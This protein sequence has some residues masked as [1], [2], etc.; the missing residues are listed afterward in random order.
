MNSRQKIQYQRVIENVKLH[1][2]E[3]LSDRYVNN[4]DKLI[5]KCK[6]DHIFYM[7]WKHLHE[8][9]WCPI[10]SSKRSGDI[11]K[12]DI[13]KIKEF[14]KNKGGE[15][16]SSEY[17][18]AHVY[19]TWKCNN[20][21]HQPFQMT[22]NNARNGYWCDECAKQRTKDK[23]K[24]DISVL[25]EE[26]NK[27]GGKLISD[28]YINA[29]TPVTWM[30]KSRHVFSQ[31]WGS[32]NQGHWCPVCHESR[33][34][35][36]LYEVLDQLNIKYNKQQPHPDIPSYYYD[37][38]FNLTGIHYFVEFDGEQHFVYR[39][40]MCKNMDEF[41]HRRNID[42]IKTVIPINC[43]IK[44]IRIDYTQRSRKRIREHLMKAIESADILY[45][46]NPE[47]YAWLYQEIP[48]DVVEKY[49]K[50]VYRKLGY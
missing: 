37:A 25:K 36:M 27:R 45:V 8:G 48:L 12:K 38:Y 11:R 33:G 1:D 7:N 39:S 19:L 24:M 4:T 30:C 9:C 47:L 35:R 46:S 22:W 15:L 26:A 43:G 29:N 2:G 14:A 18:N 40:F 16:L 10:C 23:L 31:P 44:V 6:Y 13:N 50:K 3:I 49:A 5:L 42:I 32:V 41:A 28:N 21:S 17:I 20:I 34:E